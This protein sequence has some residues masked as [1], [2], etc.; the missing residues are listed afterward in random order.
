MSRP[1]AVA[2]RIHVPG[3]GTMPSKTRVVGVIGCPISPKSPEGPTIK[4]DGIVL[5]R[6][7]TFTLGAGSANG[8]ADAFDPGAC[9]QFPTPSTFSVLFNGNTT[10]FDFYVTNGM[11]PEPGT[12]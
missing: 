3:S 7:R 11:V 1:T 2:A 4:V 6:S 9:C 8:I 5:P 12:W 10:S